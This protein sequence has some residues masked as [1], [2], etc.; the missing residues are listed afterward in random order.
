MVVNYLFMMD[1]PRTRLSLLYH[2]NRTDNTVN[3]I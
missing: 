2:H 1:F 3:S